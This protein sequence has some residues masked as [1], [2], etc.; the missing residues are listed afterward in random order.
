VVVTETVFAI[1]GVGR[2]VIDSVQ[3]HDYPVIQ[4]VLLL[5]AGVYVLINLL[6][7]LSYRLFDPRISTENPTPCPQCPRSFP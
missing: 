3:R 2:L 1:P 5:S 7:D 4:S 6:I